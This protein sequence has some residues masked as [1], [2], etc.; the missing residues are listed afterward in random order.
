MLLIADLYCI[1]QTC[2]Q[3]TIIHSIQTKYYLHGC[4]VN[5]V[6]IVMKN[7]QIALEWLYSSVR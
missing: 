6:I 4:T 5:D 3:S 2:V 1:S 7:R